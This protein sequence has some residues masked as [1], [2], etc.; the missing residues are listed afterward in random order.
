[1]MKLN[2]ELVEELKSFTKKNAKTILELGG[3]NGQFAAAAALS[4]FE[5]TVIEIVPEC[6]KHIYTLKEKYN[7]Q[8]EKLNIIEGDFYTVDLAKNFDLVLYFDGFGIGS[9]VDQRRLLKRVSNWL[10][11]DGEAYIDIYT[12][13]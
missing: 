3:G 13:W 1:M 6:V 8:K 12:P 9:D 2:T 10:R 5:V 11:A 7:I 4:G